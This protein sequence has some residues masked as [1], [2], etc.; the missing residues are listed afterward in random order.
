[1]FLTKECDYGIRIIRAL[2]DGTKKTVETIANEQHIPI[3]YTYKII[4]KLDQAN[5]VQST[6][7]RSGGYRLRK[8]LDST[9]LGDILMTID[10]G[11]YVNE[12][13]QE[14][15][16]CPFKNNPDS[17]CTVHRELE[18]IQNMIL[19]ELQLLTM[20]VALRDGSNAD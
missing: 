5:L 20:D 1:M 7:G 3:K 2:A 11:R 17:P 12:C 6:R 16:A 9:S 14:G 10:A 4:K 19:N 13:L 15:S 8:P 18:R